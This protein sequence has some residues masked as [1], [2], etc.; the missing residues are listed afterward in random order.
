MTRK[1]LD[2]VRADIDTTL[3]TGGDT[4]APKLAQLLNDVIDSSVQDECAIYSTA[5]GSVDITNAWTKVNSTTYSA[6]TGEVPGFLFP[7]FANGQIAVSPTAGFTYSVTATLVMQGDTNDRY[8]LTIFE[9]GVKVP[10]EVSGTGDGTNDPITLQV[11]WYVKSAPAN[12]VYAMFVKS[13]NASDTITVDQAIL[14]VTIQP[15]NN[16]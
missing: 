8:D 7:D 2:E 3:I 12:G 16:P 14:A 4:T 11:R 5:S 1:F 9:D 6:D 13:Q 10:V 15:T